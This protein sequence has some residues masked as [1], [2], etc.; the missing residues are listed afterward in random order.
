MALS[1]IHAYVPGGELLSHAAPGC[2]LP[3]GARLMN[4]P[5]SCT[6]SRGRRPEAPDPVTT[7]LDRSRRASRVTIEV[8]AGPGATT[9]VISG[10][11]DLVT[12]PFLAE[13][14]RLAERDEPGRLVFDLARTCFMDCA[15]A[16]LIAGACQRRP[17]P[18]RPVIRRPGPGVRRI[19]ELTG[20][21]EQ[22]EIER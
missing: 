13:Q 19:L 5:G 22:C 6:A 1:R 2:P 11:L 14:L 12:L 17:G 9:I 4:D 7:A 8:E 20:L 3:A 21:D 18:G 10:E 15:S 16:R